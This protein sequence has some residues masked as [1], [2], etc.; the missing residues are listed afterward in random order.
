MS[1]YTIVRTT[2]TTTTTTTTQSVFLRSTFRVNRVKTSRGRHGKPWRTRWVR[3]CKAPQ[4]APS[5]PV[6]RQVSGQESYRI[7]RRSWLQSTRG[8]RALV[9]RRWPRR[10]SRMRRP[11]WWTPPPSVASRLLRWQPEGRRKRRRSGGGTR[12]R[13]CN[14]S[15][16][17]SLSGH[18]SRG[19]GSPSSALSLWPLAPPRRG[20][21]RKKRRKKKLFQAVSSPGH[22][23]HRHPQCLLPGCSVLFS[24]VARP[25]TLGTGIGQSASLVRSSSTLAVA[26][27]GLV[28]LPRAVFPVVA[29]NPK[30][31]ASWP[32]WT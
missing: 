6:A 5:T 18:R 16:C 7:L 27:A 25:E 1:S 3:R 32:F 14:C 8:A 21:G 2:T 22:A 10:L 9:C 24:V 31:P 28:F 20:G 4:G 23:R 26:C 30:C 29:D 11:T 12:R 15:L 13:R 17:R 19:A